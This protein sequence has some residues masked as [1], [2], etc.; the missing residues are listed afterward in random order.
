LSVTHDAHG[1][2]LSSQVT[3]PFNFR[4]AAYFQ[5]QACDPPTEPMIWEDD[6]PRKLL[7][8]DGYVMVAT[9]PRLMDDRGTVS[10]L[11]PRYHQEG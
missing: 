3:V 7:S 2:P 6:T 10:S 9:M 1:N 8:E 5:P 11:P 4:R